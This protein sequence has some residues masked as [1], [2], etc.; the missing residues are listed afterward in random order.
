[1]RDLQWDGCINAR[2]LGGLGSMRTGAIVR[3]EAPT[4]LSADGW[5]AAWAY[6]IRT[7]VDLRHVNEG[8]PDQVPRPAGLT[9]VQV[10][11]DPATDTPFYK[12]WSQ[13]DSLSS[14][15]YFPA[16]LTEYPEVIV[17]AARAIT[18][19]PPGGVV[20]HCASGKDRTGLLSLALLALA[21]T[22]PE[23]IIADY[24]LTYERMKP[25]FDE[26]GLRDQLTAVTDIVIAH[27]TTVEASLASTIE[28]LAM[29]A[30]LLSNGLRKEELNA[31]RAR[32][33][34]PLHDGEGP[35]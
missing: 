34:V 26:L 29:P 27:G 2:D 12:H 8:P 10:P 20:I 15:L 23:V 17:A 30:F 33:L 16:L 6:G 21:G 22:E 25:R 14:P 11:Q 5:E 13:L 18:N 28:M 35:A 19:A 9:V 1:M 24:L 32:L 7:I 3:M 4:R 31:L